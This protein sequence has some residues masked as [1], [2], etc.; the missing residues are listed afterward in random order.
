MI[1]VHRVP[2]SKQQLSTLPKEERVLVLLMGHVLNQI[3]VFLKLFT[4]SSNHDPPHPIEGRISAAQSHIIL[5]VLFGVLLEGW[6]VICDNKVLIDSYMPDVDDDGKDSYK[7]LTEY[8]RRS[9][10]LYKLRTTSHTICQMP[11]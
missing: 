11:R 3:S 1:D 9:S 8:F 6:N 10:L 2:I 7:K 5:R 4:F